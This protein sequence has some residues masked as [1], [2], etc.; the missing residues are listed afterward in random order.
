MKLWQMP[1]R[2]A[3]GAFVLNSGL[4]KRPVEPQAAEGMQQMA[5]AAVP[6][7]EQLE[8]RQFGEALSVGEIALGSA[9]LTPFVP[10][11]LAGTGL[12][13][14]S[15]GLV[16]MYLNLP[17]M[18]EEGSVRPTQQGTPM[19]KD[20]WLLAIGAALVLGDIGDRRGRRRDDG[21]D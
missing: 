15:S 9:L 16:R 7:V 14:F 1:L 4:S 11:W 21:D 19:A 2:L 6:P 18:R 3:S 5:T 20:V 8:P 17:G 12:L 10:S 13:A